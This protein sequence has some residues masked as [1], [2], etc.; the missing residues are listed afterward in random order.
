MLSMMEEHLG[1]PVI[2]YNPP[3][4]PAK[5]LVEAVFPM[6]DMQPYTGQ[7]P[8]KLPCMDIMMDGHGVFSESSIDLPGLPEFYA[9]MATPSVPPCASTA[10]P[11]ILPV[12]S[13][14]Y[15]VRS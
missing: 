9:N 8:W 12:D 14:K 3:F 5:K 6:T 2:V 1:T 13:S 4:E 7:Q 11:S 15:S 10:S